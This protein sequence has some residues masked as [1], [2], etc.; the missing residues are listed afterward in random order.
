MIVNAGHDILCDQGADM[1][2]L[3]LDNGVSVARTVLHDASHLFITVGGQET[4]RRQAVAMSR[5][6][7][8]SAYGR[9]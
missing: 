2:R 1:E 4:A 7:L 6:F 9:D 8:L 3:L 5:R